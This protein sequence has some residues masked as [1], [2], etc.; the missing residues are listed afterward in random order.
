MAARCFA[1][2]SALLGPTH[3]KVGNTEFNKIQKALEKYIDPDVIIVSSKKV[4]LVP[5]KGKGRNLARVV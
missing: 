3:L 4:G 2:G 5:R 1:Q